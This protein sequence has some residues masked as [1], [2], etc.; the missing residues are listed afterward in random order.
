MGVGGLSHISDRWGPA[1]LRL[2]KEPKNLSES[3]K[4]RPK[5]FIVYSTNIA[6]K[7][8]MSFKDLNLETVFLLLK[9]PHK[10][11]SSNFSM[12]TIFF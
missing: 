10:A 5:N 3:L 11:I 7:I 12:K 2:K 1:A 6:S 4:I 8:L 9:K